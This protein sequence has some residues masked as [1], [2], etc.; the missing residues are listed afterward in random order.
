LI[1]LDAQMVVRG[2]AASASS[3]QPT[4]IGP[5]TYADDGAAPGE[6]LTAIRCRR[7]GQVRVSTSKARDRQ[8]WDF[9]LVN[10]ASALRMNGD[11]IGEA[12]WWWAP[13]PRAAATDERRT[14]AGRPRAQQTATM[15]GGWLLA[16]WPQAER[17][18]DP[19]CGTSCGR[20][21]AA[22]RCPARRNAVGEAQT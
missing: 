16:P 12:A 4:T 7:P 21:S 9:P 15:A 10:V 11:R 5:G 6:L 18:Q 8:V 22:V 13:W 1:A 14:G 19:R 17:L 20:P 3:T 2:A